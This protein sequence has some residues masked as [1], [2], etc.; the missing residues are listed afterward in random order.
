MPDIAPLV[1][2]HN[3]VVTLVAV[4]KMMFMVQKNKTG[5]TP[6]ERAVI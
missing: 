1:L 5:L 6:D 3:T 4:K 2:N